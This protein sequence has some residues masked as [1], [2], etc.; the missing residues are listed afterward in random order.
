MP[1]DLILTRIERKL[2]ALAKPKKFWVSPSKLQEVTGWDNNEMR[3]QRK[4]NPDLFRVTS[5]GGYEYNI[6]MVPDI[7]IKK[8][9]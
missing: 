6:N 4:A 7:L 1:S 8:T 2:D 5:G 3:R 9:A